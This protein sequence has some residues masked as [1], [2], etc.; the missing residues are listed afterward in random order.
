[1][2]RMCEGLFA[3][4]THSCPPLGLNDQVHDEFKTKE[5]PDKRIS[6]LSC[7]NPGNLSRS[8]FFQIY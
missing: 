8:N 5:I 7:F 3:C 2:R 1:M 6:A 4:N